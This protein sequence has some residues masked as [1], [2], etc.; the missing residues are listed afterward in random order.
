MVDG[1][2]QGETGHLLDVLQRFA[3][4]QEATR[5]S[6]GERDRHGDELVAGLRTLAGGLRSEPLV[7]RERSPVEVVVFPSAVVGCEAVTRSAHAHHLRF[8]GADGGPSW[9]WFRPEV[10]SKVY[11][12]RVCRP[13]IRRRW[14]MPASQMPVRPGLMALFGEMYGH[15]LNLRRSPSSSEATFPRIHPFGRT[16]SHRRAPR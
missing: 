5:Q 7:K 11:A 12:R 6:P 3:A 15:P 16:G 10:A 13:G 2:D 9:Q 8:G 14:P 4:P 1:L